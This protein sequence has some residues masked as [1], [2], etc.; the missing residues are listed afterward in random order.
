MLGILKPDCW[1]LR[2]KF[3]EE[4]FFSSFGL[5]QVDAASSVS[6]SIN[7]VVHGETPLTNTKNACP[8]KLI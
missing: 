3:G 7:N 2:S 6:T 5:S 4:A 1:P 8:Q